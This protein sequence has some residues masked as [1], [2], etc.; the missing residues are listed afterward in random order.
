MFPAHTIGIPPGAGDGLSVRQLSTFTSIV[1][2]LKDYIG[3]HQNHMARDNAPSTLPLPVIM[4]C[5][6]ALGVHKEAIEHVW[7]TVRDTLWASQSLDADSSDEVSR[8]VRD[9]GLLDIFL[10]HGMR[11]K[12]GAL[13]NN[14]KLYIILIASCRPPQHPP[15][16][17]CM[18]GYCLSNSACGWCCRV[19]GLV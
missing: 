14:C 17:S 1:T 7:G 11:Y 8:L 9:G 13:Q 10:A 3:W 5:A 4:F 2:C 12:L 6:E 19:A 16:H 15:S 18:P